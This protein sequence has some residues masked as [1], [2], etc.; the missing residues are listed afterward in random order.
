[1]LTPAV[2]LK[3]SDVFTP[4]VAPKPFDAVKVSKQQ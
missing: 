1:V 3:P 2:K 4:P